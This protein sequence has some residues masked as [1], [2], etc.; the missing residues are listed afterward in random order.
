MLTILGL[1]GRFSEECALPTALH[2]L[3]D[4]ATKFYTDFMKQ[5]I[6]AYIIGL[7]QAASAA[8]LASAVIVPTHR[9]QALLACYIAAMLGLF[10]VYLKNKE[11]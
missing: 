6:L 10:F 5:E 2:P 1:N 9:P 7:C 3:Y 4:V 8:L 11:N